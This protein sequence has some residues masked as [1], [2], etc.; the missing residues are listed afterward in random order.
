VIEP[1]RAKIDHELT[2]A[3]RRLSDGRSFLR[4]FYPGMHYSGPGYYHGPGLL[5]QKLEII[6]KLR[7]SNIVKIEEAVITEDDNAIVYQEMADLGEITKF[8]ETNEIGEGRTEKIPIAFAWHVLSQGLRAICYLTYGYHRMKDVIASSDAAP[9]WDPVVHTRIFDGSKSRLYLK[10]SGKGKYPTVVLRGFDECRQE[11][12]FL[13][14]S[15]L[16]PQ[17]ALAAFADEQSNDLYQFIR[18][19][20]HFLISFDPIEAAPIRSLLQTFHL[21]SPIPPNAEYVLADARQMARDLEEAFS[22]HK[23]V[24]EDFSGPLRQPAYTNA[25][26]LAGDLAPWKRAQHAVHDEDLQKEISPA[27][28]KFPKSGTITPAYGY[29]LKR[30]ENS[31][32]ASRKISSTL[33]NTYLV[34]QLNVDREAARRSYPLDKILRDTAKSEYAAAHPWKMTG[35]LGKGGFGSVTRWSR[36]IPDPKNRGKLVR[37]SAG[38]FGGFQITNAFLDFSETRNKRLGRDLQFRQGL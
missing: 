24:Q 7:H 2:A 1:L 9:G 3:V 6:Q 23:V 25:L 4:V 29:N 38:V 20:Y 35:L 15:S 30:L 22:E 8:A 37:V 34:E 12:E 21:G 19:M 33:A 27:G 17:K 18:F 26:V 14:Y 16:A 36:R 28:M 11:S 10:T 5:R 32:N 31:N 13:R